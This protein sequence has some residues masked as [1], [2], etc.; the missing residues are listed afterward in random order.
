MNRYPRARHSSVC[1]CIASGSFGEMITRS[2]PPTLAA[3]GASSIWRA[4]AIAPV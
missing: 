4:S 2:S 3:I 1:R